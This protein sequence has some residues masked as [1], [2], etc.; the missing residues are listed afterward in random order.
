MVFHCIRKT[1]AGGQGNIMFSSE[2][3]LP[4]AALA[5]DL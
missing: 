4:K 5:A 2:I 3:V 1:P